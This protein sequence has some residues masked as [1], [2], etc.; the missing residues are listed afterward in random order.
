MASIARRLPLAVPTDV[1][2]NA[3]RD[4]GNAHELFGGVL[5]RCR[6]DGDEREVTFADGTVVREL[7]V[8]IDDENRRLVYA[9]QDRFRHHSACLQVIAVA[10]GSELVW[11]TDVA[12]ETA[13]P[14]VSALMDAGL[15]AAAETL[16]ASAG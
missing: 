4:V 2:W 8:T 15:T 13:V 3:V 10:A 5:T 12:P 11:I 6:L 7:I 16:A 14:R 1:V 9:V